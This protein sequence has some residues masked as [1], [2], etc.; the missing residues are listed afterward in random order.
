MPCPQW[1]LTSRA[2]RRL[3][4]S[5]RRLRG[6]ERSVVAI[7]GDAAED[8]VGLPPSCH[9]LQGASCAS[10]EAIAALPPLTQTSS[11]EVVVYD[12]EA[13]RFTPPAERRDPPS[14]FHE[15]R[16]HAEGRWL[17]AAPSLTLAQELD[18]NQSQPTLA[19]LRCGLAGMAAVEAD[20]LH[21][22]AQRLERQPHAYED[23]VA[24]AAAQARAVETAVAI[25][26]G[27]STN[28]PGR[29]VDLAALVECVAL[30][31]D[32][33]D[34]Y[35]LNIP[36]PGPHCP[37]CAPQNP[38]VGASLLALL[39]CVDGRIRTRPDSS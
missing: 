21:I 12:L 5:G 24:E 13:W 8:L 4:A 11:P 9:P 20:G 10:L 1:I 18:G 16:R 36:R 35:W 23:F 33:V 27:L 29:P 26:A 14:A 6:L 7:L 30:T 31:A 3:V 17:I 25:T 32:I 28:P 37:G 2:A 38:Q 39:R 34:G 19:Y 22:Q 15:A